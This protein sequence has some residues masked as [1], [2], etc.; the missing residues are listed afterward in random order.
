[1]NDPCAPGCGDRPFVRVTVELPRKDERM[2]S[3]T[4]TRREMGP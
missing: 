3:D 2:K 4:L 1:M